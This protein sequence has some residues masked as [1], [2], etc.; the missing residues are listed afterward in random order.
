MSNLEKEIFSMFKN[1]VIERCK[2]HPTYDDENNDDVYIL[3]YERFNTLKCYEFNVSPEE[4]KD[5]LLEIY[6]ENKR[7]FHFDSER[8]NGLIYL[9]KLIFGKVMSYET[10]IEY[11]QSLLEVVVHIMKDQDNRFPK[12][13]FS[14]LYLSAIPMLYFLTGKRFFKKEK[15]L[16]YDKL[17]LWLEKIQEISKSPVVS[18]NYRLYADQK[19]TTLSLYHYLII[20]SENP[21]DIEKFK[22]LFNKEMG[23][24]LNE[25]DFEFYE[26]S[27][28][29]KKIKLEKIPVEII[30]EQIGK[31]GMTVFYD[32]LK[33]GSQFKRKLKSIL[34]E[35]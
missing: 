16:M 1:L 21:N 13:I 4:F 30:K 29:L 24:M 8:Y 17:T 6:K 28:R 20:L 34:E 33:D 15:A 27:T 35:N 14:V 2:D 7:Y 3:K 32:Q 26:P 12:S 10:K 22:P 19:M 5:K 25:I 23:G 31:K 11:Q 9:L 18:I